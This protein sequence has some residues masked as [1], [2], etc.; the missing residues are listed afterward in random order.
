[1]RR[2]DTI[3]RR[4]FVLDSRQLGGRVVIGAGFKF[5]GIAL[6]TLITFG[7]LAVL[8]RLL[9]PADFGY[10]AMATVVTEFAALFS[11]FGMTNVLTQRQVIN[12]LQIDT[13][14]WASFTLGAVLSVFVFAVS[15]LMGWLFAEPRAGE[16]MRVLCFSFLLGGMTNVPNVL[17]ARLMMFRTEFWIQSLVNVIRALVAIGMAYGGFGAW[18]LVSGALVSAGMT[19]VLGFLVVRYVPRFRF[20]WHYLS[21]SWKTSGIYLSAG[22]LYYANMNIDLL[23]V[24]RSLGAVSLGYYQNARSLTDEI[25][26]RIAA[27]LQ[28]ILFPAFSSIQCEMERLQQ[29]FIRSARVIAT[30]ILPVGFGVSAMS[31]DIVPVLYGNQWLEMIPLVSTFGLSAAVRGSTAIS[32][33]LLNASNRVGLALKYNVIGSLL[34][35]TGGLVG[36]QFGVEWV[37][38]AALFA[39]VYTLVP[40]RVAIGILGLSTRDLLSILGAPIVAASVLWGAIAVARPLTLAIGT[41]PIMMLV[42]H[43]TIGLLTYLL[44]LLILSRQHI[45]DFQDVLKQILHVRRARIGG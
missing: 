7:S 19:V 8:A 12:R 11:T 6:R 38:L 23:M 29:V 22:L 10:V 25:R 17:L 39:S 43:A 24:G 27:P 28:Q 30:L 14:F 2:R 34:F 31:A 36:L 20:S 16:L 26:A 33:P 15:F 13:V 18:S 1:M 9:E 44:V 5:A 35:F 40:L 45:K 3:V 37:A 32:S 21:T 4:A 41:S 42:C